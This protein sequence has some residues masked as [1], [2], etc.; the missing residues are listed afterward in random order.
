MTYEQYWH[1]DPLM[2]GAFYKAEKLRQERMDA[3]AWL[4]GAY[5]KQA[6][7]SSIGNAFLAK[8][9]TPAKYPERP[10]LAEEKEKAKQTEEQQT[11]FARLY[12]MQMVEAGKNWG[13]MSMMN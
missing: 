6:I 11:A 3:E 5:F 10:Y 7:E 1:G 4:Q 2:V 12:M 8:G 13:K 9:Q